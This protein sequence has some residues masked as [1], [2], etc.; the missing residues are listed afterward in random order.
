VPGFLLA[1]VIADC[2]TLTIKIAASKKGGVN[3]LGK[4]CKTILAF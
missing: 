4:L 1:A 2:V 3:E